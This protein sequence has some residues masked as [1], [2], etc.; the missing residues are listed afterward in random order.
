[1]KILI[2]LVLFPIACGVVVT[3]LHNRLP[4]WR[5]FPTKYFLGNW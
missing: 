5:R 1:M 4:W 3:I 2:A